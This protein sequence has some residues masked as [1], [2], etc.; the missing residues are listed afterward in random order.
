MARSAD[1]QGL[2]RLVEDHDNGRTGTR[3]RTMTQ[4]AH[5]GDQLW[6]RY[7]EPGDRGLVDEVCKEVRLLT[8][9]GVDDPGGTIALAIAGAEAAEGLVAALEDDWALYTP[10][11][12]AVTASALFAQ[13][14]A[15]G[16]ALEKLDEHLDLLAE[17]GEITVPDYD[18]VGEAQRLITA[19]ST[20]GAMGQEALGVT[21]ERDWNAAVDI[22][23]STPYF[24]GLPDSAHEAITALA[25]LL[26][27]SAK[28]FP[29]QLQDEAGPAATEQEGCGCRIELIDREGTV[30]DFH[31]DDSIWY[32][33]PLADL[34][35]SGEPLPVR[36]L[37]MAE[38]CPH[39]QHLAL[40]V[41]QT[42]QT[43]A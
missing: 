21:K 38:A 5:Q 4:P 28:F 39:P 40:L 42:L 34:T 32:L 2:P 29:C 7:L 23:A 30:W 6:R 35:S 14:T 25:G 26:G 43:A 31:R 41:E 3:V 9:C 19:Q 8:E 20:L 17:R 11:Q 16:A 22:L 27:D 15:A 33:V 24:G 18:G 12:V 10:Q 37:S 13:I 36:Q 1:R